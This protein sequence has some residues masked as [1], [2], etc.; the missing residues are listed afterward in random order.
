M[1]G[2]LW[3]SLLSASSVA[4][5]KPSISGICTSS[6]ISANSWSRQADSAALPSPTSTT[7]HSRSEEHTSELQSLMRNSYA[8]FC[9][10]QKTHSITHLIVRSH[11]CFSY[12]TLHDHH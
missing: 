8:V 12:T 11:L 7:L 4:T 10:E 3:H 2:A 5:S 6:R 9:F 1:I